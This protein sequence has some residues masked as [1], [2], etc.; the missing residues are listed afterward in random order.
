MEKYN[1]SIWRD[2]PAQWNN[3]E[4]PQVTY[5]SEEKVAIIGSNTMTSPNRA[6]NPQLVSNINGTNTFTFTLYYTYIDTET[7]EK[8]KNPFIDLITNETKIKVF[9][10]EQWYDFIVKN[11]QET[12]NGRSIQY[13][14]NDLYINELSKTGFNLEFDPELNNNQGTVQELAT[15]ILEGTDWQLTE[16]PEIIQQQIEEPVYELS[17]SEVP[18][19]FTAKNSSH[20]DIEIPANSTILLYYSVL[21]D[22]NTYLQFFY[23]GKDTFNRESS[24]LLTEDGECYYIKNVQWENSSDGNYIDC[25]INNN[26]ILHIS[27]SKSISTNY[28]AKRLVYSPITKFD[29]ITDKYVT[30]CDYTVE[31]NNVEVYKYTENSYTDPTIVQNLIINSEEFSNVDGWLS[32]SSAPIPFFQ[33]YPKFTSIDIESHSYLKIGQGYYYNTA[34]QTSTSGINDGIQTQQKFIFRIQAYT[35]SN[36]QP[37]STLITTGLTIFIGKYLEDK[38]P[39]GSNYFT[40]GAFST[41]DDYIP[42]SKELNDTNPNSLGL[43]E[44]NNGNY[45]LT[46]DTTFI[47]NKIYYTKEQWLECTATCRTSATKREL[48]Y[49]NIGFFLRKTSSGNC[50]IKKIQFYPYVFGQNENGEEVRIDPGDLATQGIIQK[51]YKYYIPAENSTATSEEDIKFLYVDTIDWAG[52]NAPIPRYNEKFK[53]IRSITEKNSNR[54]NLLQNLA[55]T[56]ECWVRF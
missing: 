30:I 12:S 9:W 56:F 1:I 11:I 33:L 2:K 28:R 15:T 50:W 32:V 53:K 38:T 45:I 20:E 27:N 23:N 6:R 44:F 5:I 40:L 22:K 13:T 3:S 47:E 54:F 43:Y 48:L 25:K 41:V 29:P 17:N 8:V 39:T 49:E 36:D 19:S 10:K 24:D 55:E 51:T 52:A 14:C 21:R 16:N 46:N 4:D 18:I 34:F 7:G 35:D 42:Y 31:N 26:I 37:T